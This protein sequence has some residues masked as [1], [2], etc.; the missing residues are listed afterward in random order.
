MEPNVNVHV[1]LKRPEKLNVHNL[2][3]MFR[4]MKQ[5]AMD[6]T[7]DASSFYGKKLEHSRTDS[8]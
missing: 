8:I 1:I 2:V 5:A 4:V 6:L 3:T 7:M